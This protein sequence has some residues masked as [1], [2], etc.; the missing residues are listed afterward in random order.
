M[1]RLCVKKPETKEDATAHFDKDQGVTLT[2]GN[3]FIRR[4]SALGYRFG[5]LNQG[6]VIQVQTSCVS[7]DRDQEI[8]QG[9]SRSSWAIGRSKPTRDTPSI[10]GTITRCTNLHPMSKMAITFTLPQNKHLV[11]MTTVDQAERKAQ[12]FDNFTAFSL[13]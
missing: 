5:K 9:P 8:T 7:R 13:T 10:P 1:D 11:L 6:E 12:V 2:Q 3:A 4:L